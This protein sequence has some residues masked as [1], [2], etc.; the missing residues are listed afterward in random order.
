MVGVLEDT[1]GKKQEGKHKYQAGAGWD[2][3][4]FLNPVLDEENLFDYMDNAIIFKTVHVTNCIL[5]T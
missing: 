3:L 2:R 4:Y 5:L 1:V